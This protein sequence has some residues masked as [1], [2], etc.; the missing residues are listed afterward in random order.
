[1]AQRRRKPLSVYLLR[2]FIQLL[3]FLWP[4]MAARFIYKLWFS[5]PR[6]TQ[7]RREQDWQK[8]AHFFH[9]K[10]THG[11][12]AV[13]EWGDTTKPV[14]LLVH[15]WSGRG[16]QLAAIVK[17]LLEKEYAVVAFDAPGHG[18]SSGKSNNL[19]MQADVLA[20][21]A[22][23]YENI[24]TVIAHSFGSLVA[25]YAARTKLIECERMVCISSPSSLKYLLELFS[26]FLYIPK[27]ILKRFNELMYAEFGE[28]IYDDISAI[29]NV[30]QL[31][32]KGLIIHDKDDADVNYLYSQKLCSAWAGAK[33]VYTNKLGHR[34]ILRNNYVLEIIVAFIC[35]KE[36]INKID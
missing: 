4:A 7:P 14:V 36:S 5:S 21:L 12:I 27:K 29:S 24:N 26:S 23:R 6:Y 32:L 33:C 9:I 2:G 16:T 34:K 28:T 8:S 25:L 19:F 31:D 3:S 10:T 1:M 30:A 15:G 11:E 17:P 20:E 13:Y 35:E 18:A 22:K